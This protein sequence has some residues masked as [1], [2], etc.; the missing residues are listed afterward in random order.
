MLKNAGLMFLTK[1]LK[2]PM[3][4]ASVAPSSEQLAQAMVKCLPEGEVL[5]IELGGGTGPI[6]LALRQAV[7]DPQQLVVIERDPH[8]F[9][10]LQQR[11][12]DITVLCGDALEM[13][14]LVE[15]LTTTASVRAVVSGLPLLALSTAEQK[16]LLQQTAA[17]TSGPFIQFSYGLYS[18]LKKSVA[19]ELGLHGSCAAQVWRNVPPAR[20]WV[21]HPQPASQAPACKEPDSRHLAASLD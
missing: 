5:V 11:F 19:R 9:R 20:V 1:W 15:H 6:T 16:V 17:L 13:L 10:Y 18:P 2:S 7:A 12:P 14:S 8:F 4:V 21:Y 3:T